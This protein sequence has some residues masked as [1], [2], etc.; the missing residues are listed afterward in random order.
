MYRATKHACKRLEDA[1]PA[2]K[3][4]MCDP[5]N[6]GSVKRRQRQTEDNTTEDNSTQHNTTQYNITQLN[7]NILLPLDSISANR[8]DPRI[9]V[10]FSIKKSKLNIKP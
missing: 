9:R 8:A 3:A 5:D 10:T 6:R 2:K 4:K 7:I 1:W